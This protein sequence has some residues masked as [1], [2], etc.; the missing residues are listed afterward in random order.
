M[1]SDRVCYRA[2]HAEEGG[3]GIAS[4]RVRGRGSAASRSC[5][6]RGVLSLWRSRPRFRSRSGNVLARVSLLFAVRAGNQLPGLAAHDLA[7]F[8]SQSV[9]REPARA[10]P[11]G[12]RRSR[13]GARGDRG[14]GGRQRSAGARAL[15]DDG[16]RDRPGHRRAAGDSFARRS[17]P[18]ICRSSPTRKRRASSAVRSVRSALDC[19]ADAGSSSGISPVMPASAA[20]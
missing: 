12:Y 8:L 7:Q 15:G 5:L 16:P 14:F 20:S 6:Q 2:A 19:R 18:S 10:R 4:R 17:S 1:P 13:R 9:P 3:S 11:G